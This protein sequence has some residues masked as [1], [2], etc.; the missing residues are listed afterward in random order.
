MSKRSRLIVTKA[1]GSVVTDE[2]K[3]MHYEMAFATPHPLPANLRSLRQL[4]LGSL[5]LHVSQF[6]KNH[7]SFMLLHQGAPVVPVEGFHPA[8][9]G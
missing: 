1:R 2:R 5:L 9:H 8:L 6:Q 4:L 7:A 3:V